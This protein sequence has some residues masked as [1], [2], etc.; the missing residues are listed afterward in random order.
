L[1]DF[2]MGVTRD[3]EIL[4]NRNESKVRKTIPVIFIL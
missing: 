1:F 3:S 2:Q 4:F